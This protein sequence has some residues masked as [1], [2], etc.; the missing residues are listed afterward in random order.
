MEAADRQPRAVPLAAAVAPEL[1]THRRRRS[2]KAK[3]ICRIDWPTAMPRE[4]SSRSSGARQG[5]Q[6]IGD[7]VLRREA[8]LWLSAIVRGDNE[9][10]VIGDRRQRKAVL[11]QVVDQ[12]VGLPVS[13][14]VD[15][16][17]L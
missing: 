4:I 7:V 13:V 11:D 1:P 8:S 17:K 14:T 9:P 3:A 5:P 15:G 6:V 16:V 2:S 12:L 10:I